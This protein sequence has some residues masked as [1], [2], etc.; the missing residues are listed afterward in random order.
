LSNLGTFLTIEKVLKRKYLK[1]GCIS[2][3]KIWNKSYGQLNDQSQISNSTS[4]H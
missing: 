3:L 1:W 4:N 2:K